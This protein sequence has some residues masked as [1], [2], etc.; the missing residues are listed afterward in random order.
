[1]KQNPYNQDDASE[2]LCRQILLTARA[3]Q[4]EIEAAAN[5]PFLF[6]RIRNQ[7]ATE[8]N[9]SHQ[10]AN[11]QP[12]NLFSSLVAGFNWRW[13]WAIPATAL[14]IFGFVMLASR[15]NSKTDKPNVIAVN[16]HSKPLPVTPIVKPSGDQIIDNTPRNRTTIKASYHPSMKRPPNR[17]S[18]S[19]F[20][21][22]KAAE[23][24]TDFLPLTYLSDETAADSGHVVRVEVPR[25]M[26]ASMGVP[27][28]RERQS[29][30]VKADVIIG[31]DG[32]ARAIRFV[33]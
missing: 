7:I 20:T 13:G 21:P 26:M 2:E 5:S 31:D 12:R 30:L 33:Q 28:N 32:L 11:T 27:T 3:D 23:E 29:E 4:E 17:I 24:T 1:M 18:Q 22:V 6:Q 15:S 16:D 14:V 10:T 19:R 8:G 25:T 9:L